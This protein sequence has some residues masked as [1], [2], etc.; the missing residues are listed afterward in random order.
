M[1]NLLLHPEENDDARAGGSASELF[2]GLRYP[3]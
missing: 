1:L 2:R 3:S